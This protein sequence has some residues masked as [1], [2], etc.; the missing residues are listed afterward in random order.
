MLSVFLLRLAELPVVLA[1]VSVEDTGAVTVTG[2]MGGQ[3]MVGGQHGL[4]Y[5]PE[6]YQVKFKCTSG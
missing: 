6:I 3:P 1:A 4:D 2:R 5:T